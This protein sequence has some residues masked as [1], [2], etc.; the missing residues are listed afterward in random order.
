[1][2]TKAANEHND[3]WEMY[4]GQQY[5]WQTFYRAK[6]LR[7]TNCF[8]PVSCFQLEALIVFPLYSKCTKLSHSIVLRHRLENN[9]T[10]KFEHFLLKGKWDMKPHRSSTFPE[11]FF[12]LLLFIG[13]Q[14]NTKSYLAPS[15]I[16]RMKIFG[17]KCNQRNN[18]NLTIY[19]RH[20]F[21]YLWR[22]LDRRSIPPAH[23]TV[24]NIASNE[25]V[26]LLFARVCIYS[27]SDFKF[28]LANN[29]ILIYLWSPCRLSI[30]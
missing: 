1:M 14:R 21:R 7:K 6:V 12:F 28:N 22:R 2:R 26:N 25:E 4:F 13:V 15:L 16:M 3:S 11:V 20:R 23:R 17:L 24:I 29:I 19:W 5:V 9:G 27:H 10:N 30:D 18:I 8:S